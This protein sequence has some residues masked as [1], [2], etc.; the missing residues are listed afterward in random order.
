VSGTFGSG[1]APSGEGEDA[2]RRCLGSKVS[3]TFG[4]GPFGSGA[5]DSGDG[6]ASAGGGSHPRVRLR[7][8]CQAPVASAGSSMN[9][10][11]VPSARAVHSVSSPTGATYDSASSAIARPPSRQS[12]QVAR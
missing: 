1:K 7:Y 6:L 12:T 3:G 5:H 9:A 8:R 2:D 4:S 10:P 11:T